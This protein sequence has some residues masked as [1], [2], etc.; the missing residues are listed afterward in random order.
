VPQSQAASGFQPFRSANVYRKRRFICQLLRHK[1]SWM[2][3]MTLSYLEPFV[4]SGMP[5]ERLETEFVLLLA[6][7]LLSIG[8]G[9]PGLSSLP[10]E[11]GCYVWVAQHNSSRYCVYVGRTTS[12]RR[13]AADYSAPFQL[14]SPNDFKLRFFE[15]DLRKAAPDALLSLYFKALPEKECFAEEQHLIAALHPA[16]NSL[17]RP[18]ESDRLVIK[19]AYRQYYRSAFRRRVSG[20]S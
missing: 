19:D 6:N 10:T 15:E 20:G 3:F 12:I 11:A 5:A 7:C 2:Q 9:S 8:R 14:H 18:V 1:F 17:P 13:R 16:I 4:I